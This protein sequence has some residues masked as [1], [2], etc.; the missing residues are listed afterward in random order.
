[1]PRILVVEDN[2]QNRYLVRFLLERA[3]YDVTVAPDGPTALAAAFAGPPD[4]VLLDIQLPGMDGYEVAATLAAD[5]RTAG[6]PIVALTSYVLP[7][8]RDRMR[9]SG[10]AGLIEKP[11]DPVDFLARVAGYVDGNAGGEPRSGS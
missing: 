3:G 2:E 9:R 8:D 7:D 1:M 11:L 4:L 10:C 5:A 6:I